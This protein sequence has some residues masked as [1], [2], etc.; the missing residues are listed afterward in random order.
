MEGAAVGQV[1]PKWGRGIGGGRRGD[2]SMSCYP[3]AFPDVLEKQVTCNSKEFVSV[4]SSQPFT[5]ERGVPSFHRKMTNFTCAKACV[6]FMID[7]RQK[8]T[9]MVDV[10]TSN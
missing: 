9:F 8:E 1:K 2:G 6:T 3:L 10:Y 7:L 5:M 4:C